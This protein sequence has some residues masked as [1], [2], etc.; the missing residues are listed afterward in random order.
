MPTLVTNVIVAKAAGGTDIYTLD[1]VEAVAPELIA[2]RLEDIPTKF[3]KFLRF[4]HP[5][6]S[7]FI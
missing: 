4:P 1:V 7:I 3:L 5:L 2:E 6:C